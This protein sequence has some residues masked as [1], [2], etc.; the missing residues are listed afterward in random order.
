MWTGE[1]DSNTLPLDAYFFEMGLEEKNLRFQK[2]FG[3]VLTGSHW[4]Q[5]QSY[6][7]RICP[8]HFFFIFLSLKTIRNSSGQM[9]RRYAFVLWLWIHHWLASPIYKSGPGWFKVGLVRNLNSDIKAEIANSVK[10]FSS[11][12]DDWKDYKEIKRL[13]QLISPP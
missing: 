1:N 13:N 6:T 3:Q 5:T 10:F 9:R 12:F 11:Q 8:F 7:R 4:Q 2:V